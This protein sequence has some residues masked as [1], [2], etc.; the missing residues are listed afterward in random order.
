MIL[1][2]FLK[3]NSYKIINNKITTIQFNSNFINDFHVHEKNSKY[4]L[5]CYYVPKR[6]YKYQYLQGIEILSIGPITT[7]AYPDLQRRRAYYAFR[8]YNGT[9]NAFTLG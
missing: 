9:P 3:S 7:T 1:L 5:K 4:V 2:K 6:I 8:Y